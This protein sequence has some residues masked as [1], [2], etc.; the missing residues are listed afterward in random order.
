MK[1]TLFVLTVMLLTFVSNTFAADE[2]FIESFVLQPGETKMVNILL[3]NPDA[4]YRDIQFDLYLPQGIT[5]PQDG[6]GE[7]LVEVGSRCTKKHQVGFSY[8]N[9]H[10]VC[11]LYS[12]G[13]APLTG[14]SGDVLSI[15]LQAS[16]YIAAGEKIGYFR[17]VS[18]SQTDATGPTYSEFS[19]GFTV[20]GK[21]KWSENVI[22]NG[23]LE[24]NDVSC[25][26]TQIPGV[27]GRN[28]A[29]ITEGVG[30]D[31]SRGIVIQSIDDP[32]YAWDTQFFIRLPYLL[33]A[34]THFVIEFDYKADDYASVG[35]QSH[36]EPGDY[37]AG[38]ID[39]IYFEPIWKHFYYE[40]T[41]S[42]SMAYGW[43]NDKAGFRTL[44]FDLNTES[45]ANTYIFDNI[46]VKLPS[47]MLE[48]TKPVPSFQNIYEG[49]T[50]YLYNVEYG[51]FFLGAN[52]WDTHASVS[53]EKGYKVQFY[54]QDLYWD[55]QGN[56]L[57]QY[58]IEDYDETKNGWYNVFVDGYNG[59]W[60]D[61]QGDGFYSSWT[62]RE[63][64]DRMYEITYPDCAGSLKLGATEYYNGAADTNLYFI[65]P[66]NS[67]MTGKAYT[68]WALV[69]EDDYNNWVEKNARY[70]AA[71]ALNDYITAVEAEI[72]G[73]DL[74]GPKAVYDNTFASLA[75]LKEAYKEVRSIVNNYKFSNMSEGT[76]CTEMLINP[77][78]A[79]GFEGWTTNANGN[80]GGLES[81]PNVEYYQKAVECEQ[82][83]T[84]VPAGVYAI[85][86][87]AFERPGNNGSYT[88]EEDA[89]VFLY[90]N[91]WKIP[92]QNICADA[93]NPEE[94]IT[95]GENQNCYL[96]G[97]VASGDYPYDYEVSG[98]GYVPNSMTGASYA[99][100]AG[101]YEQQC[102]GLVG[103]DGVMKIGIT[104]DGEVPHWVL[105]ADFKLTY[106]GQNAEALAAI[107]PQISKSLEDYLAENGNNM[108]GWAVGNANACIANAAQAIE[109][110]DAD[111]MWSAMDAIDKELVAARANVEAMKS[112]NSATTLIRS[113]TDKALEAASEE[114]KE[115]YQDIVA[116]MATIDE[117]T[118]EEI[119]ALTT[120]IRTSLQGL[121]YLY[122]EMARAG[123]LGDLVLDYVEN[124][125]DVKKLKV[126]GP[127]NATDMER[128][129]AMSSL[130][131]IDLGEAFGVTTLNSD[132]FNGRDMLTSVILPNSLTDIGSDAFAYCS[133]LET[134]VIG[135]GIT[136]IANSMFYN[137]YRLKNVQFP[138]TLKEIGS[139]AFFNCYSLNNLTL[140]EGLT[141]IGS[142]A[143]RHE[144]TSSSIYVGYYYDEEGNYHEDY[145]THVTPTELILPSTVTSIGSY[146]FSGWK[147]LASVQLNEGLTSIGYYAF[148]GSKVTSV[149]L[150]STLSQISYD[151]FTTENITVTSRALIPPTET[152]SGDCPVSYPGTLYVPNIAIKQYKQTR[153]WTDFNIVGYDYIPDDIVVT[154][155][156]TLDIKNGAFA[157]AKPNVWLDQNNNSADPQ[158]GALTVKGNETLSMGT[159]Q[160][161]SDPNYYGRDYYWYDDQN[162]RCYATLLNNAT[163]RADKVNTRLYITSDRWYFFSFPYDVKVSD[164]IDVFGDAQWV[165]RRYDGEKRAAEEMNNTWVNVGEDDILEAHQGYIW[166]MGYR[167]DTNYGGF[168]IPAI[169]NANKNNIFANDDVEVVL[170]E[171]Q[172]EFA[173]NRSW[174]LIGNPYPSYFDTHFMDFTAPITVWNRSNQNY[175]AY[176]PMDDDY[177][178]TPNEAFFVQR[179]I[180][181][182]SI[183]FSKEGR[184]H[185]PESDDTGT[186]ARA[187]K[188][189]SSSREVF[190]ILLSDGKNSDRT[191][192]V[193]NENAQMDYEVDKDASKFM[194]AS[195]SAPQFYSMNNG[196]RYA[197]NERPFSDGSVA[198]G[199]IL[200]S[201]GT[202]TIS[203]Q[204]VETNVIILEDTMTGETAQLN[205]ADYTFTA[206]SG[207]IEGRFIL[208]FIA[209]EATDITEISQTEANSASELYTL[210]GRRVQ[211]TATPGIYLQKVGQKFQKVYVK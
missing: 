92:V 210:D 41:I 134:V 72:E 44:A 119:I 84:N 198:L 102:Y 77:S 67:N 206:K 69:S 21:E 137:C 75:E 81:F 18:L 63:V 50:L 122:I 62:V 88:G 106:M 37:N 66:Q 111:A 71:V 91:G 8:N 141:T 158:Y 155:E 115:A 125:S 147:D 56:V 1:K 85:S 167:G 78:F 176:S 202:Y 150:P 9:G 74:S 178:L 33:P 129:A 104:S 130:T 110:Q 148:G 2:L 24:G 174:N 99:F 20:Q 171:Y 94:A 132:V 95:S 161:L 195:T 186:Y 117:L 39:Q 168:D 103:E 96:D 204:N 107:L 90:M 30:I 203:L 11:M 97:D 153:G 42:N 166:Q 27:E 209:G 31:D 51:G 61:Y 45:F 49:E 112:Y 183:V 182:E 13:Q 59:I 173:H 191:R 189:Y 131:E 156:M 68:T 159:F 144:Y 207:T 7:Y 47:D 17:N 10:Y 58:M 200:P 128:I 60:V 211:G 165:I 40:G 160:L 34:G 36:V 194:S 193:I 181:K 192:V 139:S 12:S 180:D 185:T 151:V 108:N 190:N 188:A 16:D 170:N 29:T 23:D 138:S 143:F 73:I 86:V 35:S 52:Q 142:S 82:I 205:D 38:G 89:K 164:I 79:D 154:G 177:V 146:A 152:S 54:Y 184:M 43:D 70:E 133:N 179:P 109:D 100:K 163:M 113:I 48:W 4:E 157:E 140:P 53:K 116:R 208:H 14:S 6:D 175:E 149:V 123:E 46:S 80:I 57:P 93:L 136:R 25:F 169:N 64:G 187:R 22:K 28:P 114:T 3:S 76:D 98:A 135:E 201:D 118:T 32:E 199:M 196:V 126:V 15:T 121:D 145:I 101:R 19:F 105:W 5:V 55:E 162:D 172:S 65:D 124:F 83:V 87:K 26:Y 127:I 120:D 197:I